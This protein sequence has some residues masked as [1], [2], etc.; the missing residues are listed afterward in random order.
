VVVA[1]PAHGITRGF[2]ADWT[3]TEEWYSFSNDPRASGA[4]VLATLDEPSYSPRGLN[5]VSLRMGDHP[6]AWTR[7]LGAGRSFYSAIGHRPEN[8]SEPH[9]RLLL[10]NGIAWAMG[11]GD[12]RCAAGHEVPRSK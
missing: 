8:Y 4:H 1:D 9:A 6:I 7:C 10:A 12:T 3:M 5:G 11:L 2:P